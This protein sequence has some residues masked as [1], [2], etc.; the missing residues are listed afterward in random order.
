ML[1]RRVENCR[2]QSWYA[3]WAQLYV[4]EWFKSL[5]RMDGVM[6]WMKGGDVSI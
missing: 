4:G 3:C 5:G 2:F 6:I 1:L